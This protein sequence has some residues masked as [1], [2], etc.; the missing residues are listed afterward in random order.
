[1]RESQIESVRQKLSL[2]VLV[3]SLDRKVQGSVEEIVPFADPVSR[4]FLVKV[5][6][7]PQED[8]Y[9]GMFGRLLI[10][11]G[12]RR[13]VLVPRACWQ[14]VGQLDTVVVKDGE[15]W[16]RIYVKTGQVQGESVEV[17]AGLKGIETLGIMGREER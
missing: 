4:T 16:R 15:D 11:I 13:T 6:L 8:L 7:P 1:M 5:A 17:L 9:P 3:T 12:T 10:P 14:R 2:D